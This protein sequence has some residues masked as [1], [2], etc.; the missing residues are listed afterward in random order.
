MKRACKRA[1]AGHD[2]GDLGVMGVWCV[3]WLVLSI[4][5]SGCAWFPK[6][7]GHLSPL[8]SSYCVFF[9]VFSPNN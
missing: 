1:G 8:E 9:D 2:V 6:A 5:D 3:P 4:S 7:D